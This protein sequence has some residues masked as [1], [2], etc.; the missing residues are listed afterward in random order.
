M[1]EEISQNTESTESPKKIGRQRG[2]HSVECKNPNP[3]YVRKAGFKKLPGALGTVANRASKK[4]ISRDPLFVQ[5]RKKIG[6][7]RDFKTIRRNLIDALCRQLL[8]CVCLSTGI[9]T[10]CV[11]RLAKELN[12]TVSRVSRLINEVMIPAGLMYV[13]TNGGQVK[14]DPNFGMVFD[15]TH[16]MWFPKIMVLTDTFFRVAGADDKLLDK[17]HNQMEV[18]RDLNKAGLA[19]EGEI[20]SLREAQIRRQQRAFDIAWKR[21]KEA[22]AVQKERVALLNMDPDDRLHYAASVLMADNEYMAL[23]A[24]GDFRNE[25]RNYLR[26]MDADLTVSPPPQQKH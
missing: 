19:K 1:I 7:H 21:R 22:A 18:H 23:M 6:R 4:R 16:G 20:I 26:R 10:L 8:D 15:R 25:C 2:N 17:L 9:P 11:E 24:Y 5:L 13:P 12:V 14:E 3:E